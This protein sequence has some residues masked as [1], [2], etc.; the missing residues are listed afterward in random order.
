MT[1][2]C[3]VHKEHSCLQGRDL[4]AQLQ[5]LTNIVAI[6]RLIY[7]QTKWQHLAGCVQAKLMPAFT[8]NKP[9]HVAL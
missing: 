4:G 2:L 8:H 1:C 6:S 5:V 9:W 7:M 3:M